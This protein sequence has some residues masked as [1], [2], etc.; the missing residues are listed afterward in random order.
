MD[1]GL[2]DKT[3]IITG[4]AKGIGA[5]VTRTVAAEGASPVIV[6][7]D[8]DAGESLRAELAAAGMRCTFVAADLMEAGACKRAVDETLAA[9]GRIDALVNNAGLNDRVSLES[10]TVEEFNASLRRNLVHYFEMAHHALPAL[11]NARGAIVNVASKVA[12]TGQ[13]ST[14]GYAASKGGVLALTREWAVELLPAG[15]RVNA[16]VPAEVMTP[17]YRQWLDTFPDPAEKLAGIVRRIPLEHRMTTPDE[18]AAMVVFLLSPRAAHITGQHMFVD[19]GYVH[20]DRT[21]I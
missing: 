4:G 12:V 16:V 21:I 20:L 6:D 3:V 5:S 14:S 13:G 8:R 11:R 7:R 19:G 17:L 9:V 2:H 1:L 10:G 15:I 18:I